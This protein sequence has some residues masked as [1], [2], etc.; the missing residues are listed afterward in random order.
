MACVLCIW[1]HEHTAAAADY[2]LNTAVSLKHEYNDLAL[3]D[4][5]TIVSPWVNGGRN[6][7][8]CDVQVGGRWEWRHYH[9][10]DE[11]S[12]LD[13]WYDGRFNALLTERWQVGADV[14]FIDDS[15]P[16]RDIEETGLLLND[17]RRKQSHVATS[18]ITTFS[19]VLTGGLYINFNH[20]NYE[21][22][23]TS[24]RKDYSAVIYLTRSLDRW[25]AR[26]TGRCNLSYS[27]YAFEREYGQ[28]GTLDIF[29]VDS[30]IAD[31]AEVDY[32][33]LTTGTESKI[34][35][36]ID[37]KVNVGGRYSW[38][39]RELEQSRSHS[40]PYF[41]DDPLR[42][43]EDSESYGF[44][45]DLTLGYRG[46][47]T[48]VSMNFSHDLEPVSGSSATAN[49]TTARLGASMRF[50]E[51]LSGNLYLQWYWNVNDQDD[52]TQDDIDRQTWNVGAGLRWG[53]RDALDLACSYSY[54]IYDDRE[55]G[56]RTYRNQAIIQL[57]AHHD[58]LE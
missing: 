52:P 24:D 14:R 12:D 23:E 27:H 22:P 32:V 2:H 57:E 17:N 43:D 50:L 5:M 56:T 9:E 4:N 45:G 28:T 38:S 13:Q 51:K 21:D 34:S 15:R 33:S 48:H 53:V 39:R 18:A 35:E 36:R 42:I 26:T 8:R 40:P 16:D 25:L 29:T 46:E 20:D 19:E 54:S 37:L 49:R 7:E 10:Y 58:W 1:L 31:K 47:R 41:H 11:T 6:S 44:V 30:I 3:S 55:A